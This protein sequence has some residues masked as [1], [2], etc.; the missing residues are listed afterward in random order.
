VYVQAVTLT[1]GK[2]KKRKRPESVCLSL[3]KKFCVFV[4][5]FDAIG[6]GSVDAL[7]ELG[8]GIFAPQSRLINSTWESFRST[9]MSPGLN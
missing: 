5:A 1:R 6:S 4:E 2:Q 7:S 9:K 8:L 3:L